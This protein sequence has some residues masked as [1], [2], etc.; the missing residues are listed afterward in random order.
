MASDIPPSPQHQEETVACLAAQIVQMLRDHRGDMLIKMAA[1]R[2]AAES[3]QQTITMQALLV[4]IN[5]TLNP[6]DDFADKEGKP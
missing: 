6:G 2:V 4:S 3:Y 1:L 5:K